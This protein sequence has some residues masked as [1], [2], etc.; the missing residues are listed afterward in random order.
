MF[1]IKG[2]AGFPECPAT[3]NVLKCR[4]WVISDNSLTCYDCP[5][6]TTMGTRR[7]GILG[8]EQGTALNI[9]G[10]ADVF[11]TA[12]DLNPGPS[13][14]RAYEIILFGPTPASAPAT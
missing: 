10:P 3:A 11:A 1:L 8:N 4:K 13:G 12:A 7:I 14:G 2:D 5:H 6:K 9:A